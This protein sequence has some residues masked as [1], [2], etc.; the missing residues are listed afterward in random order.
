MMLGILI[1][2]LIEGL[3][4]PSWLLWPDRRKTEIAISRLILHSNV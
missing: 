2:E 1:G 3:S 4:E